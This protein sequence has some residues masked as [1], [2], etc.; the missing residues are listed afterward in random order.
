MQPQTFLGIAAPPGVDPRIVKKI[1]DTVEKVCKDP[2]FIALMNKIQFPIK[3]RGHEEWTEFTKKT[4]EEM[5][6]AIDKAGLGIQ[7]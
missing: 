1:Q 5:K 4:Y 7:K 3:F 6:S 2:G